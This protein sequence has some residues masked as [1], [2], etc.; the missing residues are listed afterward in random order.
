M[1][2]NIKI[3]Q[4]FT[5]EELPNYWS[6]TDYINLLTAFNFADGSSIKPEN[7]KEML[8]MAI[9]DYEPNEAA[10]IILNY[11]LSERLNEGQIEQLS[12]DMLVDKECEKYPEIDLHATIFAVNQLL[13]QAFNGKFPPAKAT[14]INFVMMPLDEESKVEIKK[15]YVL[16]AFQNGLSNSNVIKRLFTEQLHS[17][18]EFS[19][20]EAILW[21]LNS[22]DNKNFTLITSEY[23][24]DKQELIAS[25]FDGEFEVED[26]N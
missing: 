25:E 22:A 21:E 14:Q 16:K 4:A 7:L 10:A 20:A 15:E 8:F 11:K 23:W 9:S 17:S 3:N 24:L 2:F 1:K 13:Y 6:N 12:N 18:E 5:I 26:E 19:E